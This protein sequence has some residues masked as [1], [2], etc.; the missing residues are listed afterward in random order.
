MYPDAHTAPPLP[1]FTT[2]VL[3]HRKQRPSQQ[4]ALSHSHNVQIL[5][6]TSKNPLLP[7]STNMLTKEEPDMLDDCQKK[8][9]YPESNRGRPDSPNTPLEE[10][11]IR[12]G[13]DNRYTIEPLNY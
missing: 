10:R 1:T 2:N 11:G 4:R 7:Y 3:Y 13:S 9:S 8:R 6:L 5:T 12:T